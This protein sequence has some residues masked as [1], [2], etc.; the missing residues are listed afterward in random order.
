MVCFALAS[1][2][3]LN[4]GWGVIVCVWVGE[5]ERLI[6]MQ[7]CTGLPLRQLWAIGWGCG[8]G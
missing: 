8:C 7:V 5:I 4:G 1:L 3:E 6:W 2:F